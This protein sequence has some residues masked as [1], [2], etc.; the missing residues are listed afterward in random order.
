VNLQ[1][2][3]TIVIDTKIKTDGAKVGTEDIKRALSSTMDYIKL[4]P[5][6]F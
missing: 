3:G 4:L 2:D 1:A 6:G 5:Q